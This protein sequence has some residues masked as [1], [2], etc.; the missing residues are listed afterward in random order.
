MA[1]PVLQL[2]ARERKLLG[3]I[4]FAAAVL[5]LL[6]IPVGLDVFIRSEQ[7]ANDD[8]RAA[9]ADVQ[10][11]RGRVRERKA[12]ADAIVQRYARQ[13]P[14]LAGYLEQEARQEKLEVTESTPLPDV[15][16]GKRY[17]EH[18]TDIHLKKTGML[19]VVKF[20][21]ALEQSGYPLSVTRLGLRKRSGE[22]D[23]FDV[24][25]GVSSYD[26]SAAPPSPAPTGSAKP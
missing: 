19:P 6:A 1:G 25:V 26:R 16:H 9:L 21:E 10:E 20:L 12:K 23:S 22:N 7:S 17:T 8:V 24:E 14:S 3:I 15:P 5:A 11:A 2:N 18:G 13:P 4:G